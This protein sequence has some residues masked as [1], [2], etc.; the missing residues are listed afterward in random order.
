MVTPENFKN[1][2]FA[3]EVMIKNII[4]YI[5]AVLIEKKQEFINQCAL[6]IRTSYIEHNMY[7]KSNHNAIIKSSALAEKARKFLSTEIV[8]LYREA[9][10][11]VEFYHDT[12]SGT[13]NLLFTFGK[14]EEND[15]TNNQVSREDLIDM[16]EDES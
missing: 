1:D 11:N 13:D 7:R 15:N 9:G 5:D 4:K 14:E 12:D 8:P 2:L 10:W 6:Y 16:D 3:K